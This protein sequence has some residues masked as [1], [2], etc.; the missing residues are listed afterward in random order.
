MTLT[1]TMRLDLVC[2]MFLANRAILFHYLRMAD[3]VTREVGK[4]SKLLLNKTMQSVSGFGLFLLL[5]FSF[6]PGHPLTI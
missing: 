5:M 3:G 6:G 2:Q 1:A 4:F